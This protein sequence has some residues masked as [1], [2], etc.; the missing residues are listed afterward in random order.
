PPP[1]P[2]AEVPAVPAAGVG[3]EL[4]PQR[5]EPRLDRPSTRGPDDVGDEED[6]Q[7]RQ[8]GQ[9]TTPRDADGKTSIAT[10]FPRSGAESASACCSA[11]AAFTTP[12]SCEEP[13]ATLEPTVSAG[14]GETFWSDTTSERAEEGRS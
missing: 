11:D 4:R 12:A 14:S 13:A 10:L 7:R 2:V 1:G 3:A 5:A 6:P 8:I 9:G